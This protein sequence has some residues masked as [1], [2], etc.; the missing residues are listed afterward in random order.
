MTASS[1]TAGRQAAPPAPTPHYARLGGTPAIARIVDAFYRNM[2]TLAQAASIRAL[3]PV[4]LR[5]SRDVLY[6]YL[7]G[8]LGGP[9]LYVAE[10]GPARLRQKHLPFAIGDA[11][12]DA[13]MLC[14][15]RALEEQVPDPQL[16]GELL[17]A[18][19]RTANFLR[20]R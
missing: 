2:D 9:A 3:Y 16:R 19:V 10:R 7:V 17:Q 5:S 4:D 13:W 14:M 15:R 20:N 1:D 6:K 8:W 18:L 12:R 11:E